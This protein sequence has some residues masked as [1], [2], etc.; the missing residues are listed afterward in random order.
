[1]G[2]KAGPRSWRQGLVSLR[3]SC[4]SLASTRLLY[5]PLISPSWSTPTHLPPTAE[6][7]AAAAAAPL[8]NKAEQFLSF[9][10]GSATL[11]NGVVTFNQPSEKITTTVGDAVLADA[12]APG[13][14]GPE[15][16][17]DGVVTGKGPD[18]K[19]VL[20]VIKFSEPVFANGVLTAKAAPVVKTDAPTLQGGEVEKA[21]ADKDFVPMSPE[22]KTASLTEVAIVVDS[23]A[24]PGSK[25]EGNMDVP[26]AAVAAANATTGAV[27]DASKA[28]VVAPAEQMGRRLLY[29]GNVAAGAIIGSAA[30]GGS[31]ACAAVGA[32]VAYHNQ[33]H[34]HHH[35]GCCW[36]K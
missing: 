31:I 4:L 19:K 32:N 8:S 22:L 2:K 15:I 30:C 24:A 29:A 20:T 9:S 5:P 7:A 17:A 27:M 1:M 26:A 36:G 23:R 21:L 13:R 12:F 34:H 25:P 3:V 16:K 10:A 35:H 14:I 28:A 18:G 33:W 11:D 6:P